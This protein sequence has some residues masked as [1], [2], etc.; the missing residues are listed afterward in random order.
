MVRIGVDVLGV[1][2]LNG[3]LRRD[4]FRRYAYSGAELAEAR[5]HGAE[6]AR[7]FLAGRFACKESVAKVL[8]C[9]FAGG[10]RPCHVSVL[11]GR[12]GAPEVRL[13]GP[14]AERAAALGLSGVQ[15]SIAHK[16]G[17]VVAVALGIAGGAPPGPPLPASGL[18]APAAEAAEAALLAQA[19]AAPPGPGTDHDDERR[20]T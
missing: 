12:S 5:R 9:G 7:E 10:V 15:V 2:E 18:R 20:A 16:G 14:A 8:G 4:W 19:R 6:R 17:L 3:L 1:G 11:R 13:T